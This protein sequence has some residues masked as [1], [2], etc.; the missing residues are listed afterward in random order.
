[1]EYARQYTLL[2]S[3]SDEW[4]VIIGYFI[5]HFTLCRYSIQKKKNDHE[6]N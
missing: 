2:I 4:C 5:V 6:E 1:M 3:D